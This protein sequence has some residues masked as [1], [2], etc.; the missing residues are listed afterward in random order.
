MVM[1]AAMIAPARIETKDGRRWWF[2]PN[3]GTKLGEIV[4]QRVV[5]VAGERRITMPVANEPSQDCPRC[6]ESSVLPP[7]PIRVVRTVASQSVGR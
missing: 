3:C 7:T 6:G 1:V 2:C 5:I 4:G